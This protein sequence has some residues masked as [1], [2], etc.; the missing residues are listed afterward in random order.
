[1]SKVTGFSVSYLFKKIGKFN[2]QM[3][4]FR[5]KPV[6][7]FLKNNM[8]TLDIN[9]TMKLIENFNKSA[10]MCAFKLM[11][12]IHIHICSSHSLLSLFGLITYSDWIGDRFDAD[13]LYIDSS[14]VELTLNI[15]HRTKF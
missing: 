13:F 15:F 8:K 1:M 14:A 9:I 6:L 5:L 3:G 7:H 11:R 12:Q 4:R 2:F 10:H